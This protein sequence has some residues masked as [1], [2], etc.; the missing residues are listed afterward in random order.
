M[1][2]A[3]I[4]ARGGSKRIPRKNLRDFHGKPII[5]YSVE[6]ALNSGL[7]DEVIVSTDDEEIAQ[8]ARRLGASVPFMRPAELADDHSTTLDV[9]RH[10]IGWYEQGGVSITLVCCI[11]ATAPMIQASMLELGRAELDENT[12]DY[13]FSATTFDFPVQRGFRI[14]SNGGVEMLQPEH[15]ETRSQDL[16]PLYH[17]AGQFYWGRPEAVKRGR[18]LFGRHSKPVLIP[19][20]HVQ[21]IDTL[22]DWEVA[23]Q[24]FAACERLSSK[25]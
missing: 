13:A 12:F 17:D 20:Y 19:R 4:P 6:M 1:Y 11:Y 25:T 10:A 5:T 14:L 18:E 24:I 9:I 3:V 7:F 16:E 23:E 21:D 8:L 2:L 22:E 15:M